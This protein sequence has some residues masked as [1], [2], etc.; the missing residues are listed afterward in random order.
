MKVHII[1]KHGNDRRY[2][3]HCKEMFEDENVMKKHMT[4]QHGKDRRTCEHCNDIFEGME[5]LKMH[6]GMKHQAMHFKCDQ[7]NVILSEAKELRKHVM[8][9]HKSF[10]P[11]RNITQGALCKFGEQC[12]FSHVAV[13]LNMQR[14]YKYG[15]EVNTV[16]ILMQH[17]KLIHKE[18]CKDSQ[19]K[20]CKFNQISCY[21]NH[22]DDQN[23]NENAITSDFRTI[24]HPPQPPGNQMKGQEAIKLV[25]QQI[26]TLIQ[27]VL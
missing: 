25:L 10:R 18:I 1:T 2:C 8:Q 3:E 12:H 23:G 22:P 13:A 14:C 24:S 9:N 7:C 26:V 6:L 15:L 16:S 20:T 21:L 4:D 5:E 19:R 27:S 11:C 17:R